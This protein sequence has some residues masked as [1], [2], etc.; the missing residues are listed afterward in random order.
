MKTP[1]ISIII[2]VYNGC[3]FLSSTIE[4]VLQQ[5]YQN[6]EIIC[7][8][9]GSTDNSKNLI[10]SKK[11]SRI[12]YIYQEHFG[13]PARGRNVGLKISRGE[14]IVFLDQDDI[15]KPYSLSLML[16]FLLNQPNTLFVY[17]DCEIIDENDKIIAKSGI[18][19][20]DLT[21]FD[22]SCFSH[23]F[24][25]NFI[26]HIMIKKVIFE[27]IG[28]FNEN[29]I[30]TDDYE[31]WLRIAYYYPLGF[32]DKQLAQYRWHSES[33]S[34]K[35]QIMDQNFVNC[36]DSIMSLFTDSMKLLG[37]SSFRK[38][39]FTCFYDAAFSHYLKNDFKLARL[40]LYRALHYKFKLKLALLFILLHFPS[41]MKLLLNRQLDQGR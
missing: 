25:K 3:R 30:G 29:L 15:L 28:L 14:Y 32:L 5:D 40:N 27:R 20:F 4:S 23:L 10:F 33:L 24:M 31:M 41:V 9:D 39:M 36:L 7:I 21:P 19:Y 2:P 38:R 35:S 8:D 1:L 12:N 11:D 22:G 17:S 6:F 13:C 26:Q 34:K 18:N 37:K 16:D